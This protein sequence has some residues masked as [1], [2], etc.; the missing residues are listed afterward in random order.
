MKKLLSTLFILTFITSSICADELF[1][2][3]IRG[4]WDINKDNSRAQ[5]GGNN[6]LINEHFHT[7]YPVFLGLEHVNDICQVDFTVTSKGI[8]E[9]IEIKDGI[10]QIYDLYIVQIIE[11]TSGKW[12]P[13]IQNGIRLEEDITIWINIYKGKKL[14]KSLLKSIENAEKL[15]EKGDYENAIK[16]LDI[17]LTYD[18]LN[19]KAISL[20]V[21]ALQ[22]LGKSDEACSLLNENKIY[23]SQ[24]INDLINL[25]C[26]K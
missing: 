9:N 22:N 11:S 23:Y 13:G 15:I 3:S 17:A 2:L 18:R 24:K 4:T 16:N 19:T 6:E 14:K 21:T 10:N 1:Y 25:N 8:I 5:F 20:K 12:R 7:C 26:N